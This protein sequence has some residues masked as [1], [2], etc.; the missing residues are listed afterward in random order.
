MII[1]SD[2]DLD[3]FANKCNEVSKQISKPEDNISFE[4]LL[5]FYADLNEYIVIPHYEKAPAILG[6]TLKK[7]VPFA[8]AGE[9]DST[10]KF[11]RVLKDESKLTPVLFSDSRMK[12]SVDSLPIRQTFVDCGELTIP[13]LRTCLRDK[14]KVA[15][16]EADGNRLWQVFD[17]GQKLST[18]LNVIIGAR[19]SGKTYTMNAISKAHENVKYIKQFDLVQHDDQAQERDFKNRI[20]M[21]RSNFVDD[22]LAPFKSVLD[23]VM[24]IDLS[25]R[26]KEIENYLSSLL[27]SAEEENRRDVFSKCG[28]FDEVG[29][30]IGTTKVLTDLIRSVQQVIENVEYRT[31]I[32]R[33]VDLISLKKLVL[34]L[35]ALLRIKTLDNDKKEF[36]NET[37]RDIKDVLRVRTSAIPIEDVDFYAIKMDQERIRRFTEIVTCL[38]KETIIFKK[39]MQDF[40]V[41]ARRLP[42]C[43]AGETKKASGTKIAF[44]SA[45]QVYGCPYKFLRE[46]LS[47]EDLPRSEIYKLFVGVSYKVLNKDG[48]EVSGGERSEFRLLQEI[49]DSQNYEILLIDEP[50]SSFDNLFLRSGVNKLLSDIAATMPVVVVTHNSTVGASVGAHYLLYTVKEVKNGQIVYR[51]Y[52]GRPTDKQLFTV[53]GV[54]VES[55]PILMNA[56]EAGVVAYENRRQ[57]Y[58]AL[59]D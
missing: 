44:N 22:H 30:P 40:K 51:T 27:K 4:Q 17:T 15:L 43:G 34:E 23:S 35:I 49:T 20:A 53:D 2:K 1:S 9:V 38:K 12:E 47:K 28:L 55:H 39:S 16:S 19:S 11:I 13:A 33:H 37:V 29:F 25:T 42:Y 59:K 46:L 21:E 54:A 3:G 52:S 7:L 32:E 18:R 45:F 41:E 14:T 26:E 57:G 36:T 24:H 5:T 56:L 6:D 58:E 31:V 10:K 8:C 48:F 50:E